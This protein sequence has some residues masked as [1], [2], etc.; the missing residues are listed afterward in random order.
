M[1]NTARKDATFYTFS[2]TLGRGVMGELD[3][4]VSE[5]LSVQLPVIKAFAYESAGAALTKYHRRGGSNSRNLFSHGSRGQKSQ[6]RVAAG[7]FFLEAS[8]LACR[9]LTSHHVLAGPL[10]CV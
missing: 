5:S 6:V 10:L 1:A 4:E 3:T 9:Q 8:P 7:P 2:L